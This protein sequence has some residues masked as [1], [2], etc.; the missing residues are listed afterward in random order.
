MSVS[1]I[2][3]CCNDIPNL[4]DP[5]YDKADLAFNLIKDYLDA[6]VLHN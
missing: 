2:F 1:T 4:I 3:I 5:Q 6:H